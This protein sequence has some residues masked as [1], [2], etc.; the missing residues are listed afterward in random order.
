M[1]VSSWYVAIETDSSVTMLICASH[2]DRMCSIGSSIFHSCGRATVWHDPT[3]PPC[4][5]KAQC[6]QV[7]SPHSPADTCG[8][9][10][11]HLRGVC[12]I[13]R[14]HWCPR[15]GKRGSIDYQSRSKVNIVNFQGTNFSQ[16]HQKL[17]FCRVKLSRM[18]IIILHDMPTSEYAIP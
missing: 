7:W 1:E 9:V 15:Q 2:T 5:E 12:R 8:G 18:A 17:F 4:P 3:T 14:D 16:V 10:G 6:L 13:H 11:C